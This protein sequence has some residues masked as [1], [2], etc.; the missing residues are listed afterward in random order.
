MPFSYF[1]QDGI[2]L[3]HR[4]PAALPSN[5]PAPVSTI[6]SMGWNFVNNDSVTPVPGD[7]VRSSGQKFTDQELAML[8]P[9]VQVDSVQC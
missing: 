6:Y 4:G 3:P 8:E 2:P 5:P 9:F 7:L 1:G